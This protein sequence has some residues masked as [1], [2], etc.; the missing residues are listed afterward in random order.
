MRALVIMAA[1]LTS[2]VS[3]GGEVVFPGAEWASRAPA[4]MDMD[5]ATLEA[6]AALLGGRGCV[7]KD[8]YVV[9]T[10][11]DQAERSDWMSA[12]KPVFSTMLFF[13]IEEGRVTSV[14]QP[15]ADFG[16]PL[17]GKDTG[18]TFRHLGGM[19]SGYARPE[20]PGVAWA[21]NDFAIQLYQM[22]L[23]DKVYQGD[24]A[25]VVQDQKRLGALGF[26]DG[27]AFSAKRRLTASVRD[28]ARIVWFWANKGRWGDKRVLPENYFSDYM[29]PQTPK[30]L[31]QTVEAET[32]DYLGIGSFGGGSDHFTKEGP[33]IYGFNWWFNDTGRLHPDTLT[34]PDGPADAVMAIGA[35]GNCAVFVPS[36]RAAV[37]CAK[38]RWGALKGGDP[39][40]PMNQ[41]LKLL[42]TSVKSAS[43]GRS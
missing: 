41:V 32:T 19:T 4:D 20:G 35:G 6:I 38:G 31:P 36:L 2:A 13:A 28:F 33:G 17:V 43:A 34:W 18:I 15:V 22:T 23:F 9:K 14:D 3:Q 30:D 24:S 11:G 25:E 8:G 42:S 16:W 1:V 39:E 26:Q 5:A 40:A 27:L 21:Y 12:A 10:W 37:I 29:R 7:I